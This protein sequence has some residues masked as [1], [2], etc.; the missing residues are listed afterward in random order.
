MQT[1]MPFPD[2]E[3]T[4]KCLDWRRLGKQRVEALQIWDVIDGI[5]HSKGNVPMIS[6]G[7]KNHPAVK[8]WQNHVECLRLYGSI[9]CQEWKNRGYNDNLLSVFGKIDYNCKI[10]F[11]LGNE[12][13]HLGHKS[14][15]LRKDF[16]HYSQFFIIPTDIEYYWPV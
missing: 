4:A 15:L 6:K 11:W 9:I 3:Q 14:N 10:P 1:F 12:R 2:F 13:F 16:K 8:M 5:K 7:W